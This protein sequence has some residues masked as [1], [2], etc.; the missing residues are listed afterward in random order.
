[1]NVQELIDTDF[2]VHTSFNLDPITSTILT[3]RTKL[4]GANPNRLAMLI[5]NLGENA[6]HVLPHPAVATDKSILLTANGGNVSMHYKE[7]FILPTYEW[8]G[9]ATAITNCLVMEVILVP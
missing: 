1:M 8:Y 4:L 5:V 6:V 2:G 3:T 9:I 7:D